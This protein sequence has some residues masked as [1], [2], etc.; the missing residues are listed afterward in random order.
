MPVQGTICRPVSVASRFRRGDVAAEEHRG[1]LDDRLD[2]V[3]DHR[4]GRLDAAGA[5]LVLA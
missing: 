5:R 1:R 4:L 2:A 3:A